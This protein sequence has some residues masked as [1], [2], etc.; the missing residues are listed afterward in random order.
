MVRYI[1]GSFG[2]M[3]NVIPLIVLRGVWFLFIHG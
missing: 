3:L 2:W 1:F